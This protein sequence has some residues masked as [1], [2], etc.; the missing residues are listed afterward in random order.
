MRRKMLK[1]TS[2]ATIQIRWMD[3]N[4]CFGHAAH[5]LRLLILG[6]GYVLG[7]LVNIA[8]FVKLEHNGARLRKTQPATIAQFG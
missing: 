2:A 1:L 5:L 7:K 3:L 8:F 6:F 4:L